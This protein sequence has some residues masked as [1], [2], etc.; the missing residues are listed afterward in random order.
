[1]NSVLLPGLR[2]K[3]L[4]KAHLTILCLSSVTDSVKT[5]GS[6]RKYLIDCQLRQKSCLLILQRQGTQWEKNSQPE[7]QET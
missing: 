4:L 5:L 1:M 2:I 3:G 7:I 6:E